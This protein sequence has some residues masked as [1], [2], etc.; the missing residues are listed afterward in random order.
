MGTTYVTIDDKHGFWMR[1][2]MLELWL[3]LLALHVADPTDDDPW[4]GRIRDQWLLAS[5]GWFNGCVPHDLER[6]AVGEGRSVVLAATLSLQTALEAP[7]DLLNK[8]VLNLLGIEGVQFTQ[9]IETWR[10]REV[11]QAFRDLIE[12]KILDAGH[13]CAFMPGC[14]DKPHNR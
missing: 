5:R 8:D 12:D 7:P 3:R 13:D 1:D 9:D 11:A 10:L 14:R 6:L 4:P 2:G